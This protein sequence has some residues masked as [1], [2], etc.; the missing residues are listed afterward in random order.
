MRAPH[1]FVAMLAVGALLA[2]GC[3]SNEVQAVGITFSFPGH[4]SD[5]FLSVGD[6]DTIR[7]QAYT[8]GYPSKLK[9]DS[10]LQ[11]RRFGYRSENPAVATVDAD[12]IVVANRTGTAT[13][14]ASVEG[15]TS[16][17]LTLHVSPVASELLATPSALTIN[18][19]DTATITVTALDAA[20]SHVQGPLF[21]VTTDTT[22]WT[23]VSPLDWG[24]M[25]TPGI[26]R[27]VAKGAGTARVRAYLMHER[28]TRQVD[29]KVQLTVTPR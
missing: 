5:G 19:G 8:K 23:T 16:P 21:A 26:V 13:I 3:H 12:G 9:Y 25:Q 2:V 10:H 1:P 22:W 18:V 17:P 28:L 11:P 15:V 14:F 7:A 20:G 6:R 24:R 4:Q 29:A 27:F